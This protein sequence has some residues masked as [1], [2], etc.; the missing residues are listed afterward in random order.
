MDKN[1]NGIVSVTNHQNKSGTKKIRLD[2]A[3]KNFP[4]SNTICGNYIFANL[5]KESSAKTCDEKNRKI[6]NGFAKQGGW[7]LLI[8]K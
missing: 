8:K 6:F 5:C 7:I 4:Y 2:E 1:T 3:Y